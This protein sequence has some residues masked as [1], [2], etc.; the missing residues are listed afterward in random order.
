MLGFGQSDKLLKDPEQPLL[1]VNTIYNFSEM[2]EDLIAV[3]DVSLSFCSRN[4]LISLRHTNITTETIILLDIL[5]GL[6]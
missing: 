4:N 5:T 2:L 3:F 6:F 1:N